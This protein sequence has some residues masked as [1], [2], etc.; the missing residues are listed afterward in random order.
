MSNYKLHVPNPQE[1]FQ[2]VPYQIEKSNTNTSSIKN[3]HTFLLHML[4]RFDTGLIV[5]KADIT[6]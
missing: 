3:M 2:N 6:V 5:W 1:N 4:K